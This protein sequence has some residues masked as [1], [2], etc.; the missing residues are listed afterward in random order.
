[1]KTFGP[2]G[3]DYSPISSAPTVS[4]RL[5]GPKLG[6]MMQLEHGKRGLVCRKDSRSLQ[7][8][9]FIWVRSP[10]LGDIYVDPMESTFPDDHIPS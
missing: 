10:T 4:Y 6:D 7:N 5:K 2:R 3:V 1:M 9:V 8:R